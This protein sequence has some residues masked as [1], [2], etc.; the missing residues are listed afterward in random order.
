M[1][2]FLDVK[3][4][5][6]RCSCGLMVFFLQYFLRLFIAIGQQQQ[7]ASWWFQMLIIFTPTWGNDPI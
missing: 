2:E 1:A 6:G 4:F 7:T 5:Y 3:I